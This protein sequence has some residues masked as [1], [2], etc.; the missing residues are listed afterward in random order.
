MKPE[1]IGTIDANGLLTLSSP[2]QEITLGK[3]VATTSF[4][5]DIGTRD[6]GAGKCGDG[7]VFRGS[8]A[9]R[10]GLTM[11][12]REQMSIERYTSCC[13]PD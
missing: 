12:C 6:P 2:L 3:V 7:R 1:G 4:E 8:E 9:L 13:V 5:L 11:G 10:G